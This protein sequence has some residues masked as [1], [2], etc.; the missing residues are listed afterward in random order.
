MLFATASQGHKTGGFSDRPQVDAEFDAEVNTSYEIGVKSTMLEGRL[1]ANAALFRMEIEDLQV[2]RTLPGDTSVSF[3]VQNA[4]EAVSQ[5]IELDGIYSLG[6]GVEIGGNYAY[7]QAEY[8]DFP[9]ANTAPCPPVG[10]RV[11]VNAGGTSLCN[12]EGIPLIFAPEHKGTIWAGYR[13]DNVI[14]SWG[15]SARADAKYSSEYYTENNYFEDLR[16]DSYWNYNA[17]VALISDD[18]RYTVRLYGKNLSEEY[19]LAWGLEAG[20]SRF[21]APN[22]PREIGIQLTYRH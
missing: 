8:E 15:I 21:V 17:S 6:N 20:P 12:Y 2:A 16:Q 7:T 13:A 22:A 18:G 3:E 5:G 10:G 11:E 19:V 9:G 14:G 4:A 1:Q